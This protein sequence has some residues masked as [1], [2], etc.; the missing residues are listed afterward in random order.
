MSRSFSRP[1]SFPRL[2]N[3][4][5]AAKVALRENVLAAVGSP[6]AVFDGFAGLGEMH[7]KVWFRA[8]GYVGCDRVWARDDRV[9]FAADN[10]RVMRSIDLGEFNIFDFDAFGSPWEQVI[11]LAARRRLAAGEK[12]GL[13][14]TEG[15]S[16]KLR[17]GGIPLAMAALA[18]L[19]GNIS[20]LARW[21][22]DI[23]DKAIGEVCRRMGATL[24]HRWQARG[25]SH[26]TMRYIGLVLE[27]LAVSDVAGC[28]AG[29]AG[30]PE[31]RAA[32][33]S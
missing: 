5:T 24:T 32:G 7:R 13:V 2:H 28:A 4:A 22:D 18:G 30:R 16:L 3:Q 31:D 12:L 6:A 33:L 27:G 9:C 26:A 21:H 8:A 14:L 10:R 29:S 17:Q 23:V 11:I 20:G 15:S 25:K 1:G 19:R